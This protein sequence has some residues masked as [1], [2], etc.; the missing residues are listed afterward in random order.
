MNIHHVNG[1]IDRLKAV[2]VDME[3]QM[4]MDSA[5]LQSA[6][7]AA[8]EDASQLDAQSL[9]EAADIAGLHDRAL[10]ISSQ[11]KILRKELDRL[12]GQSEKASELV[13]RL[14]AAV[15]GD[16]HDQDF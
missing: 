9:G 1:L 5:I 7:R 11:L 6:I 10:I 4:I 12:D 3:N 14:I 13:S 15:E 2:I 16:F 8:K